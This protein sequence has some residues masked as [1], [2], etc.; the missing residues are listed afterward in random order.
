ML[1]ISQATGNN[2]W[3]CKTCPC[4]SSLSWPPYTVIGADVTFECCSLPP[5]LALSCALR[6]SLPSLVFA[7]DATLYTVDSLATSDEY[8]IHGNVSFPNL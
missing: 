8:P 1:G 2:K 7:P 6:P 5:L 4:A 3:S